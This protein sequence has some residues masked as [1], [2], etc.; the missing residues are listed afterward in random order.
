MVCCHDNMLRNRAYEAFFVSRK[1]CAL[2]WV[3]CEGAALTSSA[4]STNLGGA[5]QPEAE[6]P[7]IAAISSSAPHMVL[8]PVLGIHASEWASGG[9][10][11][12]LNAT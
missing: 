10:C 4:A 1:T 3:R 2:P 5:K 12:V 8:S 6:H 11:T 9:L 7:G